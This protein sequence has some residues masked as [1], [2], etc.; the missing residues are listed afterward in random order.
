[1]CS[2]PWITTRL[3]QLVTLCCGYL[4]H[5][6]EALVA[7]LGSVASLFARSSLEANEFGSFSMLPTASCLQALPMPA[8]AVVDSICLLLEK[9]TALRDIARAEKG[10]S[11]GKR[12][13]HVTEVMHGIG[14]PIGCNVGKLGLMVGASQDVSA[15]DNGVQHPGHQAL[16]DVSAVVNGIQ[17]QDSLTT[18]EAE[19]EEDVQGQPIQ[20]RDEGDQVLAE[21]NN[22]DDPGNADMFHSSPPVSMRTF[23]KVLAVQSLP[24]SESPGGKDNSGCGTLGY[25]GLTSI[26]TCT[27]AVIVSFLMVV[28]APHSWGQVTR[29]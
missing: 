21:R 4:R 25:L 20:A 16:V 22:L 7:P 2:S 12:F 15:M 9:V 24:A 8:P 5:R 6:L 27:L 1:M 26:V 11:N 14:R 17:H 10:L 18:D 28:L 19:Y 13:S 29:Y 23:D 3:I